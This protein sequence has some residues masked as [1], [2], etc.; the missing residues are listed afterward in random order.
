M[1][2]RLLSARDNPVMFQ[3]V[4]HKLMRL[5]VPYCCVAALVT[6]AFLPG[7][8]YAA[9]FALQTT[10]YA[11][12]ILNLTPLR[13]SPVATLFRISWTFMV[14]NAAAVMGLWVFLTGQERM[15][16]RKG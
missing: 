7:P 11:L 13:T 8:L 16:W 3:F 14:L 10:F 2:P 9:A 12:G 4:S 6:S 1:E 15:V 5:V